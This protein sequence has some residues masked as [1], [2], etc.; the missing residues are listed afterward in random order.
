MFFPECVYSPPLAV[1]VFQG[2][3]AATRAG[4]EVSSRGAPFEESLGGE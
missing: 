1:N 2:V 4:E 3:G